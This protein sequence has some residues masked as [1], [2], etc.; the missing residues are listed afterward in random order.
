MFQIPHAFAKGKQKVLS[1]RQLLCHGLLTIVPTLLALITTNTYVCSQTPTVANYEGGSYG[2]T[3]YIYC[4]HF[5]SCIQ[6]T[7]C[8]SSCGHYKYADRTNH[9]CHSCDESEYA[10][11]TLKSC[12]PSDRLCKPHNDCTSCTGWFFDNVN[13]MPFV[14]STA[15]KVLRRMNNVSSMMIVVDGQRSWRHVIPRFLSHILCRGTL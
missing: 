1:I 6:D 4:P 9:R 14:N 8:T 7:Q 13:H 5:K 12:L 10:G 2:S 3:K 15:W 11:S